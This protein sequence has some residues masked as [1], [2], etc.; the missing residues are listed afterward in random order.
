MGM[1]A[2]SATFLGYLAYAGMFLLGF[3]G[4]DPGLRADA[5]LSLSLALI[6]LGFFLGFSLR[7]APRSMIFITNFLTAALIYSYTYF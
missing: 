7:G 4:I 5:Y 2:I 6:I 3:L 1:S